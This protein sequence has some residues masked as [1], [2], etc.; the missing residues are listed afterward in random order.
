LGSDEISLVR[1]KLQWHHKAF[2]IPKDLLSQWR[3]I[4]QQGSIE[5]KKWNKIYKKNRTQINKIFNQ[6]FSKEIKKEKL[7][8]DSRDEATSFKKGF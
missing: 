1:K 7:S 6:N 4:G 8:C 2:D 5:E 3:K